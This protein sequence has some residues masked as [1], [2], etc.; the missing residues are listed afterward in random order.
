MSLLEKVAGSRRLREQMRGLILRSEREGVELAMPICLNGNGIEGG[1]RETTR[2][3]SDSVDT[4][5]GC[6][7]T[8]GQFMGTMHS[9]V[10]GPRY[11]SRRDI[12]NMAS[13]GERVAC[14]G[15]KDTVVCL[16]PKPGTTVGDLQRTVDEITY[17][18]TPWSVAPEDRYFSAVRKNFAVKE[19]RP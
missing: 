6:P 12:A 5:L 4:I 3:D 14:T 2:G 13:S 9:H 10:H 11:P 7:A 17:Y 1:E 18:H 8:K 16:E 19:F 15:Q